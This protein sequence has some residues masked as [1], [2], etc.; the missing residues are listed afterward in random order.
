MDIRKT[1]QPRVEGTAWDPHIIIYVF[2]SLLVVQMIE[3]KWAFGSSAHQRMLDY[4][5]DWAS[6]TL[7]SLS[8]STA[9][10]LEE[11]GDIRTAVNSTALDEMQQAL[12]VLRPHGIHDRLAY[13]EAEL[14][15]VLS[16][17][18]GDNMDSEAV[19][20]LLETC[21]SCVQ[22]DANLVAWVEQVVSTHRVDA[23][24]PQCMQRLLQS[25]EGEDTT[26][27]GSRRLFDSLSIHARVA[28]W[29]SDLS[30]WQRQVREKG[31]ESMREERVHSCS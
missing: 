20:T 29:A 7:I 10:D 1:Y 4:A 21:A 6:E 28:L 19:P 22:E 27:A 11:A 15:D 13:A 23:V 18:H 31:L 12:F 3:N 5:H 17:R 30:C 8:Q 24:G 25:R 16:G 26:K 14:R 2:V 9:L